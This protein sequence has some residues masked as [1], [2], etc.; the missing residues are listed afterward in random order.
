MTIHEDGLYEFALVSDDGSRMWIEDNLVLDNDRPHAMRL[1]KD[2]TYLKAG[3]Y[4]VKIWYYQAYPEKYGLIFGSKYL[5]PYNESKVDTINWESEIF[6][7]FDDYTLNNEGTTV[8]DSFINFIQ[9]REVSQVEIIGH[10]DNWGAAEY[11]YDLSLKRARSIV[12]YLESFEECNAIQF[13]P[14]GAGENKPLFPN[15]SS[16][17]RARNRRVEIVFY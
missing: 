14:K 8:L 12:S 1:K 16:R 5:G 7:D 3:T 2:S 11:N 6:F 13:V 17:N 15:D 9:D 4:P 10:T